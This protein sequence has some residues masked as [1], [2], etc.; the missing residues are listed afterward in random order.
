MP[1]KTSLG[2]GKDYGS[3]YLIGDCVQLPG[4]ELVRDPVHREN[5]S[6]VI[7]FFML[8]E[9][10]ISAFSLAEEEWLSQGLYWP[11][12]GWQKHY[13]EEK[14]NRVLSVER[15]RKSSKL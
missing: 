3:G 6:P 12:P 14:P 5:C 7:S 1:R 9:S 10:C 8:F 15:N 2:C 13:A 11:C 4:A